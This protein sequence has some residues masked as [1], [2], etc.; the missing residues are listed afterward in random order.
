MGELG[1]VVEKYGW[2]VVVVYFLAK[3]LFPFF[4]DRVY[5]QKLKEQAAE[6]ARLLELENR[7]IKNE[8]RLT[9]AVETMSKSV[10]DMALA[11][12]SNNERLS[13]VISNQLTHSAFTE[14]AINDMRLQVATSKNAKPARKSS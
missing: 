9:I 11:I 1:V 12:T 2:T 6:R 4:R 7:A 14:Q 13:Q 3:D 5:P 10:T 8:E